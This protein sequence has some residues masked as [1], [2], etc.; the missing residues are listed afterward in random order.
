[1]LCP[2]CAEEF[3]LQTAACPTCGV[4]LVPETLQEISPATAKKV[5][6]QIEFIEL[7]RP[8][9][10]PVA[11]LI[12][13]TLEQNGIAVVVNGGNALSMLPHLAF[14]GELRVLVDSQQF[15]LARQ[16]YEAYFENQQDIDES[17]ES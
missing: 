8:K 17:P 10:Y 7:C 14:G 9:L 4:N 6:N 13:Q 5:T 1:M 15:E 16:L 3:W 12:K 11:M 2:I